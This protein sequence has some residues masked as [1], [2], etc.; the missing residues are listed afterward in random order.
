VF[1]IKVQF[2]S[3]Q[4]STTVVVWVNI[5]VGTTFPCVFS[6]VHPNSV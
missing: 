5:N 2:S 6:G 4:G 1:K 3:A